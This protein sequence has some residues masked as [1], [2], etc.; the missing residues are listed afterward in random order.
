MKKYHITEDGP[1]KCSAQEGNCPI[2][3][4]TDEKHYTDLNIATRV[5]EERMQEEIEQSLNKVFKDKPKKLNLPSSELESKLLPKKG[6]SYYGLTINEKFIEQ[7]LET[8][9]KEIGEK[10]AK[11]MEKT[12]IN[13][14]GG[15][16]FHITALSPRET[17]ELKKSGTKIE[18]PDFKVKL[19]GIGS[20]QD[21]DKEAWFITVDSSDID[22]YRKK[23]NLPKHHLHITIGFKN[24]DVHNKPKNES[25]LRYI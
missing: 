3:K 11:E 7:H 4:S 13:R 2:T 15:Y 8:W 9:R 16:H 6:G 1:K 25:S 10:N 19:T 24:G 18:L 22:E 23:L 14:D 21:R 5:Y 12:K 20:V 17:R